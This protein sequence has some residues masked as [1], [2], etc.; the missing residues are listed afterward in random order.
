MR[1]SREHTVDVVGVVPDDLLD[2]ALLLQIGEGAAGERAVDLQSVDQDGDCDE[3][4]GLDVLGEFLRGGLVEDDGVDGL[5]LDCLGMIVSE[6]F[7]TMFVCVRSLLG[8]EWCSMVSRV[9]VF[10]EWSHTLALRPLLLL[11]LASGCCGR[12]VYS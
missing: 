1:H 7:S 2:G 8:R 10:S 12:L 4:V 3:A 5:V 9:G 6:I 11:L